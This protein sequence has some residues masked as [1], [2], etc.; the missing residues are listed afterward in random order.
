MTQGHG[1]R[2]SVPPVLSARGLT[3]VYGATRA[4]DD[5][6]LELVPGEVVGLL[7]ENGAGKSTL[8][9]M[10]SG[11]EQQDVGTVELDGAPLRP[12]DP[13]TAA[14][15]GVVAV[16][17]ELSLYPFLTVAENILLGD[18]P[19]R[20]GLVSWSAV[21]QQARELLDSL[22]VDVDPA[23]R[24]A[25]LELAERYLVEIAKASRRSPKVLIL[26]EPTAALDPHD[27]QRIFAII[28]L[29]RASGTAV[30]F[31]SHRLSEVLAVA[32]RYVVLR[33]GRLVGKGSLAGATEHDLVGLMAGRPARSTAREM[34]RVR[35]ERSPGDEAV[36][37]ESIGVAG[38][39]DISFTARAG[40]VV[41]IAGLRGSG[42][43]EL[44]RALAGALPIA[45]GR[46]RIHGSEVTLRSPAQALAHGIGFVPAERKTDGLIL[47]MSVQENIALPQL[48][49]TR[50]RVASAGSA[51]RVAASLVDRLRV[52]LSHRGTHGPVGGLSGGNQQKVCLAKW[53][54]ADVSVLVLDEP[55]RGVDVAAKSAI[56]D[57][58][59]DLADA[60]AC[61]V[62]SSSEISELTRLCDRIV[63]LHRGRQGGVVTG[64]DFDEQEIVAL[65]VG[66]ATDGGR[67]TQEPTEVV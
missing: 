2:T 65:A 27:V 57:V 16:Y 42:R 17:Q 51:R 32:R 20:V 41:G 12:G 24:V 38:V 21:H 15:R 5:V 19:R 7:G 59:S 34:R 25:D 39:A 26:D 37:L 10:V 23:V 13:L 28:E 61:L 1:S 45:G 11:A 63:V 62:V 46:M 52:K 56:H 58:I 30:V 54:A 48:V 64:P 40:E 50:K 3:K 35:G 29:L 18:Y 67:G 31:V 66:T 53:L 44:C 55:T 14:R 22:G 49:R 33:D 4:I 6:S 9:K 43:G 36:A 60:G 8:L 47:S